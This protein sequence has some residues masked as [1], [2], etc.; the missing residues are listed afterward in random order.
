[1]WKSTVILA[2]KSSAL[3]FLLFV[4]ALFLSVSAP[5]KADGFSAGAQITLTVL[6]DNTLT[7]PPIE[8]TKA[9]W[10]FSI[11]IKGTEKAILFDTGGGW[12]GDQGQIL[13][14]N[15]NSMGIAPDT[16]DLIIISH[17][18]PDHKG[19]LRAYP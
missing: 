14:Q 1:M 3:S 2:A 8:G 10:G 15:I 16:I 12:Y 19:G 13:I 9:E 4:F 17:D 18:H 11:F 7:N 6:Y 5:V